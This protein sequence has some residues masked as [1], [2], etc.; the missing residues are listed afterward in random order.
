VKIWSLLITELGMES[1]VQEGKTHAYAQ[2]GVPFAREY[3]LTLT[4]ID[5]R[6]LDAQFALDPFFGPYADNLFE[7][8]NGQIENAL[9]ARRIRLE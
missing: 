9:K 6:Y 7:Y 8:F 4:N 2:E 5:E 1:Q 3:T